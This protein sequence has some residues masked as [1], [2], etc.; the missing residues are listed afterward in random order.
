MGQPY[1]PN[2][3]TYPTPAQAFDPW[4]A[5][6]MHD[7]VAVKRLIEPV[8]NLCLLAEQFQKTEGSFGADN[9][10]LGEMVKPMLM[11]LLKACKE[12]YE[13]Q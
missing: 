6:L 12:E 2:L 1:A 13:D 11:E 7:V 8:Q 4:D 9:A 5:D 3:V 10:R